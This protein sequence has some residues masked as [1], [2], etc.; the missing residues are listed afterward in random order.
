MRFVAQYPQVGPGQLHGIEINPY[1]AE[2]ARV[3]IWIGEIQWMLRNGFAYLRDPILRPLDNIETRDALIDWSDPEHPRE[4]DWPDAEVIIGNPPFLG[5]KLLAARAS[6]DDYVETLFRLFDGRRA[7]HGRLRL[8]LAREGARAWSGLGGP[9]GSGCSRRRASAAVRSRRVL[10]RIKETGDI[11]LAWSDEPWVLDGA[12]VH[13]SFVGFDDGSEQERSARRSAGRRHQREPDRRARPD[14]GAPS[15][16]RTSA[17]PSWATR[18]AGRSTSRPRSPTRCSTPTTP[19]DAPTAMW[20]D[21]GSTGW[22]SRG[23]RGGMWII[24][25]GVS[26]AREEAALYQAPFEYV[27]EHVGPM[28]ATALT[29]TRRLVA[30]RAAATWHA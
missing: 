26:M 30:A 6:G 14:A 28:R 17:S 12:N 2:L 19:T 25:F 24:D 18:R 15:R 21:R 16:R 8:L 29:T 5:G 13:V 11:F 3:T 9:S 22:T 20:F 7:R 4:A 10:E 23:A 27:R 1:A